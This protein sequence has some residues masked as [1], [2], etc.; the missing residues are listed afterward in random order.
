MAGL[1]NGS[2]RHGGFVTNDG[3][4]LRGADQLD[5]PHGDFNGDGATNAVE[6]YQWTTERCRHASAVRSTRPTP[7]PCT[8]NWHVVGTGTSIEARRF[9]GEA[10]AVRSE[11]VGQAMRVCRQ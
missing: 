9:L 11:T 10:E 8:T 5:V 2:A 3:Q 7:S 4:C 1:S 6:Q